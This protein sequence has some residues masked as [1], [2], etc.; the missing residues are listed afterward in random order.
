[1][2]SVKQLNMKLQAVKHWFLAFCT[3][4]LSAGKEETMTLDRGDRLDTSAIGQRIALRQFYP[5]HHD[6]LKGMWNTNFI[7]QQ[8]SDHLQGTEENALFRRSKTENQFGG[9]QD[10]NHSSWNTVKSHFCS[11]VSTCGWKSLFWVSQGRSTKCLCL[12][13]SVSFHLKILPWLKGLPTCLNS[14]SHAKYS[15]TIVLHSS[16]SG[17]NFRQSYDS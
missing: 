15:F 5:G 7:R 17:F 4:L 11:K 13:A 12:T 3:F 1:M 9:H 6:W 2:K 8:K 14:P 10:T 16:L